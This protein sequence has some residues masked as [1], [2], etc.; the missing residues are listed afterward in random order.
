MAGMVAQNGVIGEFDI[1]HVTQVFSRL[2]EVGDNLSLR[3][4][5]PRSIVATSP[6]FSPPRV[7]LQSFLPNIKRGIVY[8]IIEY[9]AVGEDQNMFNLAL[10]ERNA[11]DI[12]PRR[13]Q[14]DGIL[15]TIHLGLPFVD[16]MAGTI[17]NA[18]GCGWSFKVEDEPLWSL[19]G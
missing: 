3:Y 5:E 15:E 1:K 10:T 2:V 17:N 11:I 6:I 12:I 7:N 9:R 19:I 8:D 13:G 16:D 4:D 18:T 14:R